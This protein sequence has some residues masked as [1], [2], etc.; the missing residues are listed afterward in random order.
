LERQKQE[1]NMVIELETRGEEIE[2][3]WRDQGGFVTYI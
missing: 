1:L 3:G 2:G